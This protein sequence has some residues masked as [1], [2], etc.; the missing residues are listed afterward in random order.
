MIMKNSPQDAER[1][2]FDML[3]INIFLLR[4]L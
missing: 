4:A 2:E 3:V 1:A